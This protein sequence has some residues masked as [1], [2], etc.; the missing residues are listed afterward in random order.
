[1]L[2]R[3]EGKKKGKAEGGGGGESNRLH[4]I[5]QKKKNLLPSPGQFASPAPSHVGLPGCGTGLY[6]PRRLTDQAAED[7]T[8]APR[9]LCTR[10]CAQHAPASPVPV[11]AS[12][13]CRMKT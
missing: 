2:G 1:M 7:A 3:E 13:P 12:V 11:S 4:A 9:G 6:L 8:G 10:R 5:C